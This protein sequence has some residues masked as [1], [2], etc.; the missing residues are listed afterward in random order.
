MNEPEVRLAISVP[1][2]LVDAI[3]KESRGP[4]QGFKMERSIPSF[5]ES[6]GNLGFDPITGTAV[7]W[8]ALKFIG[9]AAVTGAVSLIGKL[10]YDRLRTAAQKGQRCEIT[11]RYP[12]GESITISTD[13]PLDLKALEES[14]RQNATS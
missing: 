2:G 8:V 3:D 1:N 9:K 6:E 13:R 4:T 10:L 12:T 14:I 11:I 5:P 7:V